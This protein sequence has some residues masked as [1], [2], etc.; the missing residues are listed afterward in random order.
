MTLVNQKANSEGGFTL[1][2]LAIVMIIIGLLIGGVLKGQ[3]LITNAQVTSTVAQ[4]KGLD[5]AIST[6]RDTYNALPGD[7]GNVAARLPAGC[8]GN[9][10]NN[11]N[12]DGI[13]GTAAAP[14]DPGVAVAVGTGGAAN[15]GGAFFMHMAAVDLITGVNATP[16]TAAVNVGDE[17]PAA[18]LGGVSFSVGSVAGAFPTSAA[19]ATGGAIASWRSGLYLGLGPN[20]AAAM[21][22]AAGTAA[23]APVNAQRIDTKV[24]DGSPVAGSVR[25]GGDPTDG[26]TGCVDQTNGNVYNGSTQNSSCNLFIRVQG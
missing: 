11:G 9:C 4:V 17:V 13:I 8:T 10:A 19:A 20:P 21:P 15:E 5:A 26:A 18:N 25:A 7:I 14:I 3:E 16:Q 1:V 23:M 12:G 22:V 24:D 2:E 6:F